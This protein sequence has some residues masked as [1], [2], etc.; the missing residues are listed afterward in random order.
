MRALFGS[1][2]CLVLFAAQCFAISGGPAYTK[3]NLV[4]TYAGALRP[5]FDPT[6]PASSNSI[7][8]F[9]MGIPTTGTGSGKFVMFTQ[10]RTFNGTIQGTGDPGD[11]TIKAILTAT[12]NYTLTFVT[13]DASGAQTVNTRSVT[14]S[15]NGSM[16]A[17]VTTSRSSSLLGTAATRLNGTAVLDIDEGQVAANGQPILTSVI[18]LTVT[19]F[20]QSST[21]PSA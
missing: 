15:V 7:G 17:G 18:S 14:A 5:A 12:F 11:A 8:I 9:S 19:G 16:N 4:G 2:L 13:T 1:L 10:G 20:K 21:P 6:N 3:A